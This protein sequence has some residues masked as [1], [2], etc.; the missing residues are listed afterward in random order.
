M[1][2]FHP[3]LG[4]G[5]TSRLLSSP[6]V[7]GFKPICLVDV[8]RG[9]VAACA[10]SDAGFLAISYLQNSLCLVDLRGP[11]IILREGFGEEG[12]R[13]GSINTVARTLQFTVSG[14]GSDP[15]PQVRLLAVY[16]SGATKV[17]TVVEGLAGWTVEKKVASVAHDSLVHPFASF[18]LEGKKGEIISTNRHALDSMSP[19]FLCLLFSELR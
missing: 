8:R 18:V 3:H 10:V 16:D 9:P 1:H 7:D 11:E 2:P 6:A 17:F 4:N 15:A 19:A 5:L 12:D 13:R 14:L